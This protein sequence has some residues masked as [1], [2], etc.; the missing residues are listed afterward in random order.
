MT[1]QLRDA[2]C[3]QRCSKDENSFSRELISRVFEYCTSK[4]L[5][6]LSFNIRFSTRGT[7][8]F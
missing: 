7:D 1:R 5:Q 6:L 3:P 2:T 4:L 8:T